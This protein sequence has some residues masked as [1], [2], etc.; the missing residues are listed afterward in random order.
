MAIDRAFLKQFCHRGKEDSRYALSEP[1]VFIHPKTAKEYSYG[2]DGH[3]IVIVKGRV[4]GCEAYSKL[5][6]PQ[7]II[8]PA[9]VVVECSALKTFLC[10]GDPST[11]E[12]VEEGCVD[13]WVRRECGHCDVTHQCA[14]SCGGMPIQ[15][16]N[17]GYLGSALLNRALIA[18]ALAD[19]ADDAVRVLVTGKETV[20]HI[21][22]SDRHVAVMPMRFD[23]SPNDTPRFELKGA[24]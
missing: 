2:T 4:E 16:V 13:G 20:V 8:E 19:V 10:C 9:G 5:D 18:P 15:L 21:F 22:A 14:C 6:I 17:K 7:F 24:E 11:E 12:C 23:D 1:H 3:R